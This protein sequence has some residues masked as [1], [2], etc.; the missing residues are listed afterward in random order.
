MKKLM[1]KT[2]F[3]LMLMSAAIISTSTLSSCKRDGC[4]D[5]KATNFDEKAK[6]DDGT[7]EYDT[8]VIVR[9]NLEGLTKI[10]TPDLS[11]TEA[12]VEVYAKGDLVTGYNTLYIAVTDPSTG[13]VI[14]DAHLKVTPMMDM[15][16]GHSHTTPVM[17]AE[18]HTSDENGL[19]KIGVYFVMSSMGGQWRLD[20]ELHNHMN[21]KEAE[22]SMDINVKEPSDRLSGNF[23][24]ADDSSRLFV[25]WVKDEAPIVG[26]NDFKLAVFKRQDM[27]TFVPVNDLSIS[28]T[29]EM[30]TMG[31]GSPGNVNPSSVGEGQYEGKVNFTMTGYW[32]VNIEMTRSG[33]AV[34]NAFYLDYTL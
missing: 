32:K 25:C 18:L 12:D 34:S 14:D 21:D 33:N 4:T 20:L 27:M 26:M 23:I 29:P 30:P 31:H 1:K 15:D 8:L 22:A 2:V 7:C 17:N 19:Y 24:A 16:A 28:I 3:G 10:G 5:E 9:P 11:A 6:K 13:G